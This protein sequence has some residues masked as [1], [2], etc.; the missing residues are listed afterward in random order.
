MNILFKKKVFIICKYTCVI[1][2]MYNWGNFAHISSMMK[3]GFQGTMSS[4]C[5][6]AQIHKI[7]FFITLE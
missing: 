4:K 7:F 2:V 1:F 6:S 5:N 3:G